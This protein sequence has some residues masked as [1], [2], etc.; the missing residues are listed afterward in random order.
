MIYAFLMR[1]NKFL[2]YSLILVFGSLTEDDPREQG[3]GLD[4]A[5]SPLWDLL[6][7][8][9]V[10]WNAGTVSWYHNKIAYL[11]DTAAVTQN[12]VLKSLRGVS[13]T[14]STTSRDKD[15]RGF[16]DRSNRGSTLPS[17]FDRNSISLT[18]KVQKN[19]NFTCFKQTNYF[20]VTSW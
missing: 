16:L 19:C 7:G 8:S 2:I 13:Y 1:P 9:T 6:P 4:G 20:I 15:P 17:E 5:G 14:G 18:T 11:P 12:M 3:V 10:R